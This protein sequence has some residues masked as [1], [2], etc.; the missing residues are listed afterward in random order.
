MT[1]VILWRHGETEWNATGRVQGQHDTPLSALGH[2]QAAEAAPRLAALSP[3]ALYS[4]DL[5]RAVDTAAPLAALTGLPVTYDRRLRERSFGAFEGLTRA[6]MLE[7]YPAELALW[8]AGEDVPSIGLEPTVDVGKR[9]SAA[10]EEFVAAATSDAPIVIATHGG[11]SIQGIA[12]LLGWPIELTRTVVHLANCHWSEL[13]LDP[14]R[15]WQLR[16]HNLPS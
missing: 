12:Y 7:R 5:T 6:D 3:A 15:G 10:I 8:R 9:V 14:R 2:T 4:S 13:A 16:A 1:R 11:A